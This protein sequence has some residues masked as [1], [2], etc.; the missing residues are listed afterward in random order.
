MGIIF[1]CSKPNS[2]HSSS[3]LCPLHR[4]VAAVSFTKPL[5]EKVEAKQGESLIISCEISK[6]RARVQWYRNGEKL[7][8]GKQYKT[9]MSG[10]IRRLTI[11]EPDLG[12]DNGARFTCRINENEEPTESTTEIHF[13]EK[14]K[15]LHYFF[16]FFCHNSTSYLP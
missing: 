10:A 7:K 11:V 5:D 2:I 4:H 6:E 16:I 9:S 15:F 12:T 3:S 14:R 8:T 13:S 1:C